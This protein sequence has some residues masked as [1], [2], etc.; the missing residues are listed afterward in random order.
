V[1]SPDDKSIHVEYLC[2]HSA[3]E[4]GPVARKCDAKSCQR[5][6]SLD[7]VTGYRQVIASVGLTIQNYRRI[8]RALRE[9]WV[10]D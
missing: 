9:H 8:S 6:R 3:V 7:N 5:A 2:S 4:A 10:R 1:A